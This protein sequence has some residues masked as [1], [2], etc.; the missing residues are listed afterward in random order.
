M[1][2]Y[3]SEDVVPLNPMV[4]DHPN[5]FSEMAIIG[6][7]GYT[8][9]SDTHPYSARCCI[10]ARNSPKLEVVG[11]KDTTRRREKHVSLVFVIH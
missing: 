11:A 1:A 3:G 4:D 7:Y 2:S 5:S 6:V 8:Q 9:F 10:L